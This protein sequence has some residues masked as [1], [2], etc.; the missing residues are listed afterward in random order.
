MNIDRAIYGKAVGVYGAE[1]TAGSL[2]GIGQ[3]IKDG[4]DKEFSEVRRVA[5]Y[6]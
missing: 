3:K 1:F 2:G 6:N 4:S 5:E